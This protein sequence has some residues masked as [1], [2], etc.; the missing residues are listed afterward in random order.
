M[1]NASKA[2]LMAAGVLV[3]AIIF[4]IFVYEM[5]YVATTSA[6]TNERIKEEEILEFNTQF[7]SYADRG[8]DGYYY[9]PLTGKGENSISIQEFATLYN[10]IREWNVNN[11]SITIAY[12]I[13]VK[14]GSIRNIYGKPRLT[15][16]LAN[17]A[18]T[19]E[20][21]FTEYFEGDILRYYFTLQST[22]IEY[23]RTNRKSKKNYILYV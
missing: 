5:T 16:Y 1:E 11:P 20:Q 6:R 4:A 12:D 23:Y 9:E 15:D 13:G 22:D 18:K 7:T 3:G 2:L 19:A 21:L 17:G 8:K 14:T 10:T